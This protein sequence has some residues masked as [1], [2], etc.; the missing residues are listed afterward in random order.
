MCEMCEALRSRIN[1]YQIAV[2]SDAVTTE[3][4]KYMIFDLEQILHGMHG[5][6]A[7][8]VS[9]REDW[10]LHPASPYKNTKH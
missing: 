6:G 8:P 2:D 5:C 1:K 7:L 4:I 10:S 9:R 3:R